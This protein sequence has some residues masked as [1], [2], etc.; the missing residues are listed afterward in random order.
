MEDS[1]GIL[2]GSLDEHMVLQAQ[3]PDQFAKI[4]FFTP[5]TPQLQPSLGESFRHLLEST[6]CM[7]TMFGSDKPTD[8]HRLP[9]IPLDM[10]IR[11]HPG[12]SMKDIVKG[13]SHAKLAL[14]I[15]LL[16]FRDHNKSIKPVG[17]FQCQ[18]VLLGNRCTIHVWLIQMIAVKH[19]HL[20][21]PRVGFK[22]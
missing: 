4:C 16:L 1:L 5:E 19:L 8:H 7:I 18:F 13:C 20:D 11:F 2:G 14:N 21:S 9:R 3:F 12:D 15:P 22:Q 17:L 6:D 10:G